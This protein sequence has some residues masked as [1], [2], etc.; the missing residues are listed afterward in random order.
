MKNA[1]IE[2]EETQDYELVKSILTDDDIW[3]RIADGEDKETFSP[4]EEAKYI[5]ATVDDTAAGVFVIMPDF[6]SHFQ[7]LKEFRGDKYA[8]GDAV[9]AKAKE[10]ATRITTEIGKN[11]PNVH[12]FAL[13]NGYTVLSEDDKNWYY[14][15]VL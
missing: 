5:L 14:E 10:Y 4:P 6:D 1:M 8:V 7:L 9:L 12:H 3:S 13:K 11:H 15:K 2:V